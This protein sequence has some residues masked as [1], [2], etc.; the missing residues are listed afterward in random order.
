MDLHARHRRCATSRSTRS[1]SARAPTA[2]S[3]TCGPPPRCCEGRQVADGSGCWSSPARWRSRLQAEREGLDDIFTAAGADWRSAGC[4]MCLGMNPD[5]LSPGER[6]ASTSN[7]NFEGRQGKGGRTHL[8]SPAGRRR[9]RRDRPPG[10]TRRP[11]TGRPVEEPTAWNRSPRTPAAPCRCAAATSTPT[12]SSR[13]STSSGSAAPAS[14]RA[15]SPPGAR[16]RPSSSTSPQ[17]AGRDDPGR[18]PDFG[19][20]SSREHAVWALTD[21]GFRAV[22]SPR[23]GDIFR[24]NS[25]KGG[26]LPVVLPEDAVSRPAGRGRGRTGHRDHRGPGRPRGARRDGRHRVLRDRRLHPLAADGGPGR[27]R[28]TLRHVDDITAFE[29][30]RPKFLPVT[31]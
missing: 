6:S 1:S 22:I 3:R 30:S 31:A 28:L 29:H 23:F 15:C 13:P 17:Y 18:G 21:Y 14:G 26:L 5:K 10:R 2:G 9:H 27:H 11:V 25:T 7:R 4:S 19:T 20:G 8:V 16:T 24:G 12:R